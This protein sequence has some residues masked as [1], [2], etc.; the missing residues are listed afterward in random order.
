MKKLLALGCIAAVFTA[1][2]C[3]KEAE[4][5]ASVAETGKLIPVTIEARVP[6]TKVT[7]S[8]DGNLPAWTKG[9]QIGIFTADKILCPPFSA[10]TGGSANTTFTG[11]K[12]EGSLLTSAFFPYD[13][14][15]VLGESGITITLPQSQSG[16]IAD[17]V[18]VGTG[19]ESDGFTFRNVCSL[20]RMNIPA[21]LDIRKVEVVRD[22]R[23]TG[24]F[25]VGSDFNVTS[26][27][28]TS[29]LEKRAEVAG[30]SALSGEILISVLP[31]TSKLIQMAL[32]RSD[33]KVAFVNTTFTSGK[34]YEAGRI[35]N[36]GQPGTSLTF[37]DAALVA[38]PA[39]KQL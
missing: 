33:G 7:M 16:K 30:T 12:P 28:P 39:D 29:Y 37:H 14:Q 20:L 21:S 38:D 19:N 26:A 1:I 10:Q 8:P 6:E 13:A 18:M 36:L 32:T 27:D 15:A 3:Q 24:T 22:D 35:K 2:S 4:T 31:S 23:V 9:D 34:A 25:T 5:A 11:E 17:A